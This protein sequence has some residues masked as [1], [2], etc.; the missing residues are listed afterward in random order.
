MKV[1]ILIHRGDKI[2]VIKSRKNR[3]KNLMKKSIRTFLAIIFCLMVS[4][5]AVGATSQSVHADAG[6]AA[7]KFLKGMILFNMVVLML[8][9]KSISIVLAEMNL[10]K[11]IEHLV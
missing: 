9:I 2:V 8:I 11:N 3:R 6:K 7:V 10:G 1:S 4:V 5:A